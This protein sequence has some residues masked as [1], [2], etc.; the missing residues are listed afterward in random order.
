MMEVLGESLAR[1][2]YTFFGGIDD[3]NLAEELLGEDNEDRGSENNESINPR[4][5]GSRHA[6][7]PNLTQ[8]PSSFAMYSGTNTRSSTPL[9]NASKR[10]QESNDG[11]NLAARNRRCQ[12]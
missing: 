11:Y 6:S 7:T 5:L 8:Q 3:V 9:S 4:L 12:G 10:H 1:G 2:D